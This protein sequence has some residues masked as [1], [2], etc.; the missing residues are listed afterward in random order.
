LS[1]LFPD[2]YFHIGGDENEGKHWDAN[3]EIQ[4]YKKKHGIADNHEL[5][6]HFNIKILKMLQKRGKIMMGWDEILQPILPKDVVIH[7]WRGIKNMEK[8]AKLGYKTI[9]SK[10]YYIDL[11]HSMEHHYKND[12]LGDAQ[13]K[14]TAAEQRNILGGEATMWGELVTQQ[15][16]DG[17]IWPRTA[18]IAERFWSARSLKDYADM[19]RRLQ[20]NSAYLEA[21][22][23][24]HIRNRDVILR[25][26]SGHQD[27]SALI[28]WSK[29]R[30]PLKM[31]T[32]NKGGTEYKSFSPFSR[33][34]DACNTDAVDAVA[35][36][37]AVK[38]YLHQKNQT[39]KQTLLQL[40]EKW[41]KNHKT[42]LQLKR[43]PML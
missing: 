33:F 31:Y 11:M 37:A 42:F 12:P 21:L 43:K 6:A 19:V 29:V 8:A 32:R 26:V 28:V 9:L 4:A 27:I 10:G 2:T 16:I 24:T 35:F 40:L 39:D 3:T 15:T 20:P 13:T 7:S 17:R 34:V 14:L 41:Q 36:N 30:E 18:A 25:N 5:Q 1:S 22:G 23:I 38:G